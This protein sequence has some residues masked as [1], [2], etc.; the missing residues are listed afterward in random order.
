MVYLKEQSPNEM[1]PHIQQENTNIL[2]QYFLSKNKH[3]SSVQQLN[4][5]KSQNSYQFNNV[6]RITSRKG[7]KIEDVLKKWDEQQNDSNFYGKSIE[8]S[9]QERQKQMIEKYVIYKQKKQLLEQVGFPRNDNSNQQQ[10]NINSFNNQIG[11]HTIKTESDKESLNSL[12][13]QQQKI[14]QKRKN[15]SSMNNLSSIYPNQRQPI[16]QFA[17]Q[18]KEIT[19]TD[20]QDDQNN[21]NTQLT[22][23]A[24]FNRN[25]MLKQK[26]SRAR[27]LKVISLEPMQNSNNSFKSQQE[28]LS[29]QSSQNS[30]QQKQFKSQF[31]LQQSKQQSEVLS[32]LIS[33]F[34]NNQTIMNNSG[35]DQQQLQKQDSV[36][37]KKGCL[38][39][40]SYSDLANININNFK[41]Q[42]SDNKQS[43][44]GNIYRSLNMNRSLKQSR[45]MSYKRDLRVTFRNKTQ[46]FECGRQPKQE[47]LKF[48][49]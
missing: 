39:K 4:S 6:N 44:I 26:K 46:V 48:N 5:S 42:D 30:Q 9:Q 29:Q 2:S 8:R 10:N 27:Q 3:S 14:L 36:K 43:P 20:L 25:M 7:S 41:N 35:Q 13:Q 49:V 38:K 23:S 21:N 11:Q 45:K 18:Q 1:L 40:S 19:E 34:D 15:I 33:N 12:N 24:F 31:N 28:S 47:N 37:Q 16:Y 22:Q 17:Q 32:P